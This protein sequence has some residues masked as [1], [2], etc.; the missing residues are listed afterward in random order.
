MRLSVLVLACLPCT[1]LADAPRDPCAQ[2]ADAARALMGLRQ[3]G[4]S[5]ESLAALRPANPS[6]AAD[7]VQAVALEP[8]HATAWIALARV[9]QFGLLVGAFC[10]AGGE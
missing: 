8:V 6:D 9:E 3:A 5:S 2:R 1:A 4:L 10:R 7:L